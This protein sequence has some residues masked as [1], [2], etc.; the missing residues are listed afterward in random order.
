[1]LPQVRYCRRKIV[2]PPRP[3]SRFTLR[4]FNR[5]PGSGGRWVVG[6][7]VTA[8]CRVVG[9]LVVGRWAWEDLVVGRWAGV[10]LGE[11]KQGWGEC[12]VASR[13]ETLVG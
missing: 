6:S 8:A 7:L 1:M 3:A 9:N 10:A 12:R 4:D 2:L 5:V 13:V 11:A